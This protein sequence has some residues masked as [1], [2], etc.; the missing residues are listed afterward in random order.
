LID[1]RANSDT[2]AVD[3]RANSDARRVDA[4]P[5]N[6]LKRV[7]ATPERE[8]LTD[9][10]WSGNAR[11]A[12]LEREDPMPKQSSQRQSKAVDARGSCNT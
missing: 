11:A 3:A 7:D 2:R 6:D 10:R 5:S 9:P 4:K 8:E 12:T 1:P